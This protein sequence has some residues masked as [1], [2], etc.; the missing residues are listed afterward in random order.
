MIT[1]LIV[2][3]RADTTMTGGEDKTAM[4]YAV[5]ALEFPLVRALLDARN[6]GDVGMDVNSGDFEM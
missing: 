2:E 3:C 6:G 4:Y 5:K 1:F